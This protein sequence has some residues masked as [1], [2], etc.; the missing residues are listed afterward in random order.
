MNA[1]ISGYW[2]RPAEYL[3]RSLGTY[4]ASPSNPSFTGALHQNFRSGRMS[5]FG[6]GFGLRCFQPLSAGAWLPGMP[7]Q[8]TG[9]LLAPAP[10][11]SRTEGPFPS[12][13]LHSQ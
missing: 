13:I 4:T 3:D 12:D 1:D 5:I 11:S 6:S 7:C 8:T 9:K 10:R 2:G